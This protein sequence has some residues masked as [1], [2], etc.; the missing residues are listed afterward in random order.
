MIHGL[1]TRR[2]RHYNLFNLLKSVVYLEDG[3]LSSTTRFFPLEA[4]QA[5]TECLNLRA[6]LTGVA[7]NG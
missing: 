1:G 3:D 2:E 4:H 6:S 7:E 5:D